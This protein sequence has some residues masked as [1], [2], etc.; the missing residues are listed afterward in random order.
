MRLFN[1]MDW[2]FPIR[3][4]QTNV[5]AAV[6]GSA[7]VGAAV[8]ADSSRHAAN[9]QADA[10]R[11]ANDTQ[12]AQ[13]N[14]TREDQ[15]PW[16]EAGQNALSQL[17]A[18]TQPGGQFMRNFTAADFQTDPGYQFRLSEGMKG[19]NN[20]AAARGGLL[21]GAALKAANQYNQNFASNE[22]SNAYNRFNTNRDAGY[23]KLASLSGVGQTATNQVDAA[24]QNMAN[25]VSENTIG[26]GNARASSYIGGANAVNGAISTATN[27]YMN[28][29][30][31][32]QIAASSLWNS[33]STSYNGS[34]SAWG[35]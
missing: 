12:M 1:L 23:N 8:S 32:N 11:E 7:V 33:P 26:V 15:A 3:L 20:S 2:V 17:V 5:A 24:G 25:Q 6:V 13:Y 21:S 29:Q 19:I 27:G 34:L 22:F 9:T 4:Y 28:N 10:A 35:K 31:M 14:Q 18:G 30:L 16:R